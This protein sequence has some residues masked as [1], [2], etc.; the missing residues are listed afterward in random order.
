VTGRGEEGDQEK[1]SVDDR[2]TM[3][4]RP[5]KPQ[6]SESEIQ[7]RGRGLKGKGME[8]SVHISRLNNNKNYGK[9]GGEVLRRKM[10]SPCHKLS[11]GWREFGAD[12]GGHLPCTSKNSPDRGE[13]TEDRPL[14]TKQ[15]QKIQR[16]SGSALKKKSPGRFRKTARGVWV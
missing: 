6:L 9:K 12:G 5:G 15:T 14:Q 16:K 4:G 3:D 7:R 10:Q 2:I 8:G 1:P 13:R 11:L